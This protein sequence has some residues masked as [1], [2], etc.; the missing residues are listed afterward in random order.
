MHVSNSSI[1]NSYADLRRE[2][3]STSLRIERRRTPREGT[4]VA[5]ARE[6]VVEIRMQ[7]DGQCRFSMLSSADVLMLTSR[8]FASDAALKPALESLLTRCL[9][10]DSFRVDQLADGYVLKVDSE[11]G[12]TLAQSKV[13]ANAA[14]AR[15][16]MRLV[17]LQARS[18]RVVVHGEGY[19]GRLS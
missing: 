9:D 5:V 17:M 11:S 18:V 16:V 4:S 12:E 19:V 10:E 7:G 8:T 1:S 13:F 6:S 3:A 2:R 14:L 15:A